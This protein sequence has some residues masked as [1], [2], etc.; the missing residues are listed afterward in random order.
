GQRARQPTW[1]PLLVKLKRHELGKMEV[2]TDN[3]LDKG[4]AR[5]CTARHVDDRQASTAEKVT[6][7]VGFQPHSTRWTHSRTR[8]AT[9]RSHHRRAGH[10]QS[11]QSMFS[12]SWSCRMLPNGSN[13]LQEYG[14]H[15]MAR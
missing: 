12:S 6:A 11:W 5:R 14:L 1:A 10:S 15:H 8:K 7:Q 3:S 4:F 9:H 2:H 13:D